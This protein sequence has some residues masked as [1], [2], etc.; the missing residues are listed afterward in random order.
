MDLIDT[1]LL[2]RTVGNTNAIAQNTA[3]AAQPEY[4]KEAH[5]LAQQI[6]QHK[7]TQPR[8]S[9]AS[10]HIVTVIV[11]LGLIGYGI[12]TNPIANL[13][14]M[15]IFFFWILITLAAGSTKR[16]DLKAEAGQ[17]AWALVQEKLNK[18][19]AIRE[20]MFLAAQQRFG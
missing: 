5:F 20:T 15:V 16:A 7:L 3:M 9:Y 2:A 11:I 13:I 1:Y 4:V 19:A 8:K 6:Y 10:I 18:E 12:T 14:A 17:E